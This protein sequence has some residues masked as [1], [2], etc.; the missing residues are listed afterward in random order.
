[1]SL[2]TPQLQG[3]TNLASSRTAELGL[4]GPGPLHEMLQQESIPPSPTPRTGQGPRG[5]SQ[6]A[7]CPW[8][9][10]SRKHGR[11]PLPTPSFQKAARSTFLEL[12]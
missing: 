3:F 10:G 12:Q 4:A 2:E 8:Y 11:R 7:L 9:T 6:G 5:I 1:M